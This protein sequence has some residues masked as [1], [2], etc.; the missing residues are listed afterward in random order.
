MDETLT[1]TP[2]VPPNRRDMTLTAARQQSITPNTFV[3]SKVVSCAA[4]TSATPTVGR[5]TPA[6][7][8]TPVT[9]P[10]FEPA[11]SNRFSTSLSFVQSPPI[12]TA[13]PPALRIS[14]TIR[15]ASASRVRK[16][17]AIANPRFA[18]RRAVAAPI[19]LAP[20]VTTK[21]FRMGQNTASVQRQ[22]SRTQT[23]K[24]LATTSSGL[25]LAPHPSAAQR[26]SVFA[27]ASGLAQRARADRR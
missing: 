24:L 25:S 6:E 27:A 18:A 7:F 1:T 4:S 26:S 2:P 12:A 21:T 5:S 19:P 23:T 14:S 11:V 3:I 13:E 8:T 15:A 20:P 17:I 16:L 22:S 9:T 10:S